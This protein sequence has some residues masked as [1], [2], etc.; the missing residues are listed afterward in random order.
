MIIYKI[1]FGHCS[2]FT[3]IGFKDMEMCQNWRLKMKEEKCIGLS[4]KSNGDDAL[5]T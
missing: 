1:H 5:E 4:G 2:F 3:K